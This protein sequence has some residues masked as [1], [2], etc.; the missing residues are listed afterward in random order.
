M[1]QQE[2]LQSLAV[3]LLLVVQLGLL[4]ERYSV[5]VLGLLSGT[6]L[7]LVVAQQEGGNSQK[8]GSDNQKERY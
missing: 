5:L 4:L 7:E 8:N 6:Y 3:V 1:K 2:K